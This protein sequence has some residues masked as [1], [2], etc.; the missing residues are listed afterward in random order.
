MPLRGGQLG[1]RAGTTS[2]SS[3]PLSFCGSTLT[4]GL[5]R[6][7]DTQGGMQ[8]VEDAVDHIMRCGIARLQKSVF[9]DNMEDVR[10]GMGGR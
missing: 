3:F 10:A 7:A 6:A 2:F 8:R 1:G 9:E 4:A 5:R